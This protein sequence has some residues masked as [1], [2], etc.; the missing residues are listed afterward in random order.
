MSDAALASLLPLAVAIPLTGAC[1]APLVARLSPRLALVSSLTFLLG[2]LALLVVVSPAV[3]GG[4]VLVHYLG[5]WVPVRGFAL[6]VAFAAD[7]FGLTFALLSAGI[8][9]LLVLYTLSELGG[10]GARELGGFAALVQLLLAGLIGAALTADTVDLFVWFEVA[11]LASYG[12]TGFFLE[13]PPALEA[14][15]KILVLTTIAGFCVFIAAGLLYNTHG[16]LNYGQLATALT[17]PLQA[18]D[19]L[20]LGLFIAGFATKAGLVPFHGWLA[21]AHTAA[22][23]PV[24]AL[25]SGLMV[26]LGIVGITRI[27]LQIYPAAHTPVLGALMVLGVAS[28]LVGACLALVQDDLKRLLAYDTVSQVGVI[29]A[30]LAT[31]DPAGVAGGVY[32]LINHAL[33]KTLLFLC[34]GAIVHRT[35]ETEL[36]RMGGLMRSW[37]GLT[38]AFGIGVASIAG[39]P[40]FNGYVS[41][42]LIHTGLRDSD[43]YL[44]YV[45]LLVAQLITIAAL[46]RAM[47]LAFLKPR[48]EDYERR[49]FLRPGM[50]FSLGTLA[51]CCVLFGVLPA[52]VLDT[53]VDPAVSAL[54]NPG[55]YAAAV[56]NQAGRITQLHPGFAYIDPQELTIALLSVG[57]GILLAWQVL[58]RRRPRVLDLLR[59][60]HTGSVNDYTAYAVGGAIVL[61]AALMLIER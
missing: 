32:H 18:A 40:P 8:G 35:G 42:G 19:L 47:W 6:G 57:L 54:L 21:D 17:G 50:R 12:L 7:P 33:F 15:F 2:T 59:A 29:V 45:L 53:I 41:V 34:A 36:S 60:L 28:A 16:A 1:V 11:A 30:G 4:R 14:A 52:Y 22:P 25:F 26:N 24:S 9:A 3:F 23:G 58:R 49:E 46:A 27:A 51:G 13:R 20:A 31:A 44:P 48:R 61:L 38:V 37:P 10:L 5:G 39:V 55:Q 56:L 43:Q